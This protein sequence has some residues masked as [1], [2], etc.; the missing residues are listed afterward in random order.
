MKTRFK[1]G[2]RVDVLIKDVEIDE[3]YE[4]GSVTITTELN[5]RPRFWQMPPQ[6]A[7]KVAD[8]KGWPPEIGDLWQDA[9]G[10]LWFAI[11]SGPVTRLMRT[12]GVHTPPSHALEDHGPLSL[13]RRVSEEPPF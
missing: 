8:P 1:A 9:K 12:D 10:N 3:Q 4:D 2:D 13:V 7:V 11:E 5:G 6:A